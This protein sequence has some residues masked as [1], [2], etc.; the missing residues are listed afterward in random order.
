[1]LCRSAFET[2]L[3]KNCKSIAA[4]RKTTRAELRKLPYKLSG[5]D[6]RAVLDAFKKEPLDTQLASSHT[7]SDPEP[8]HDRSDE[9]SAGDSKAR[10]RKFFASEGGSPP[11]EVVLSGV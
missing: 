11:G 7:N 8:G 5:E 10:R 1:M 4:I 9:E 2:S 3:P 6:V